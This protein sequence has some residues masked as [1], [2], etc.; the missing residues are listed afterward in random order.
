MRRW[1]DDPD[2]AR[3]VLEA[4]QPSPDV[5]QGVGTAVLGHHALVRAALH[6]LSQR[7]LVDPADLRQAAAAVDTASVA[8]ALSAAVEPVMGPAAERYGQLLAARLHT[9][10]VDGVEHAVR[11]LHAA[12]VPMPLAV[13]RTADIAGV[14]PRW[15]GTYLQAVKGPAVA[16]LVRQDAADR[17]LMVYANRVGRREHTEPIA[18]VTHIDVAKNARVR[19]EEH[20]HRRDA[21]GKFTTKGQDPERQ[22][23]LARM[24]R[25]SRQRARTATAT[26][27]A[28]PNTDPG[29]LSSLASLFRR[30]PTTQQAPP[31]RTAAA[32]SAPAR[33]AA[34]RTAAVTTPPQTQVTF[35]TPVGAPDEAIYELTTR[36]GQEMIAFVDTA[37]LEQLILEGGA[38]NVGRLEQIQGGPVVTHRED[39]ASLWSVYQG[40][41]FGRRK[42]AIR[43]SGTLPV[44]D[45]GPG[46]PAGM[47]IAQ[48]AMFTPK[49]Y[50]KDDLTIRGGGGP[51]GASVTIDVYDF[52]SDGVASTLAKAAERWQTDVGVISRDVARDAKG[53]FSDVDE[54]RARM[55]RLAR[56]RRRTEQTTAA[57]PPADVD[58]SSLASLFA[59]PTT[60]QTERAPASRTEAA[61]SPAARSAAART[62][63][64]SSERPATST[65]NESGSV[66]AFKREA[67]A[68]M[69]R[70]SQL[71]AALG[72][73]MLDLTDDGFIEISPEAVAYGAAE[74]LRQALVST[75]EHTIADYVDRGD[76]T[77]VIGTFY[78]NERH[79]AEVFAATAHREVVGK[80]DRRNRT[81]RV[82]IRPS[83]GVDGGYDVVVVGYD[84][85]DDPQV[86]V[87]GS[88]DA[89]EALREGL[90]VEYTRVAAADGLADLQMMYGLPS[91][92]F[93]ADH[94]PLQVL[95]VTIPEH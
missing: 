57:K 69:L 41:T 94:V 43:L 78:T 47:E 71:E 53:R 70:Q 81:S 27:A 25:T 89:L 72:M 93:G 16:P 45:G 6:P 64:V 86:A 84:V 7:T 19:F 76:N 77:K 68:L 10:A 37:V 79:E 26:P 15:A 87:V 5:A 3:T 24:G 59:T 11:T 85:L 9:E 61:R 35:A 33:T 95:V 18:S 51:F 8:K 22:A 12:G 21:D 30:E 31:A 52:R 83:S 50:T 23:R 60:R 54:R 28:P 46:D 13:E 58:M 88:N 36:P 44:R 62:S 17:A 29:A 55:D 73:S 4:I 32:R 80:I 56:Q 14:P 82:D 2:T 74:P 66:R 20:E 40:E 49:H 67:K 92:F 65:R 90:E 91:D 42:T 1:W 34:A 38:F 75:A 48:E 39:D 63:A